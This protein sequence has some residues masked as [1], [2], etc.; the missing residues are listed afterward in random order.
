MFILGSDRPRQAECSRDTN[1]PIKENQNDAS[2]RHHPSKSIVIMSSRLCLLLLVFAGLARGEGKPLTSGRYFVTQTWSQ[3]TS[4]PRPYYV[5]VPARTNPSPLPVFI[6]LHG[7]EGRARETMTRFMQRHPLM[8]HRYVL[9][10]PQGYLQ[11][12]NIVSE[13]SKADDLKFIESIIT[14]IAS[15][16]N[17]L[18]DQFTLMGHS[19]GAALVNQMAIESHLPH[20][21]N[22]VTVASPLNAFQ[23]DGKNFKSKGADNDY[24]SIARPALNKR[25]LNISGTQD[26]L[27]PYEGGPSDRIS[28]QGDKLQFIHAED[29]IYRWARRMG[30]GGG[31][32]VEPRREGTLEIFSYLD[33]NVVHIKVIGA[34]HHAERAISETR[35][36]AF[37][38]NSE[39]SIPPKRDV[40]LSGQD[41]YHTYRI[42]SLVLTSKGTLLAICEGRKTGSADHGQVDLVLKRSRDHGVNWGPMS[43]IW[44]HEGSEAVTIG[45]PCAVVDRENDRI[46]LAMCRDQFD[47]LITSSD[48]D[49]L[50]WSP[51]RTITASIKNPAWDWP[52][53]IHTPFGKSVIW[54]GPGTGIQLQQEP[55]EGRLIIP[56]HMRPRDRPVGENRMWIFY[57]D[58][59][60]TTWNHSD[61]SALGNE[62]QVVELPSG[63][64]LLNGRNQ[65]MKGGRP[66]HRLIAYSSDGGITWSESVRDD[67]LLEPVCQASLISLPNPDQH[68]RILF[69]NPA[70]Q[71]DRVRMTV[72]LSKDGGQTWP[73]SR[74]VHPERCEYSSLA[75]LPDEEIGLLFKGDR[76]IMYTQFSLAWLSGGNH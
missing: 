50:S 5:H 35:L 73:V 71:E 72:R 54:T 16:E 48:D 76:R 7:T 65:N 36:L 74:V 66:V 69:A 9:V 70:D 32:L 8:S 40:F 14:R 6:Y 52:E 68:P 3:Q 37:L 4:E 57:S 59:H 42:P 41:G 34:G 29:S 23:H 2:K 13:R 55:F 44:G 56:C 12:W 22:Y 28:A 63:R 53:S 58:D 24:T 61:N 10:F 67:E 1:D 38:E 47:V 39:T 31:K 11:S 46:W 60:G 64:L 27:V 19:N 25:I 30:T 18:P 21:R 51:P 43:R 17:I 75:A 26:P 33:G 20:I 49:G 45:N 62:S 15:H